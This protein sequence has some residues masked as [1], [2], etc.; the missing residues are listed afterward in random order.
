MPRIRMQRP[1]SGVRRAGPTAFD[2]PCD[3]LCD[4]RPRP[5]HSHTVHHGQSHATKSSKCA[6]VS[7]LRGGDARM[8]ANHGVHVKTPWCSSATGHCTSA[9]FL[10]NQRPCPRTSCSSGWTCDDLL[11]TTTAGPELHE[12]AMLCSSAH[13]HHVV[14]SGSALLL[15]LQ[16]CGLGPTGRR[17]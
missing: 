7:V 1:L 12:A 6:A 14:R 11:G 16:T 9:S 4:A 13:A 10:T 2:L 3:R 17:R 15:D 8:M 5:R